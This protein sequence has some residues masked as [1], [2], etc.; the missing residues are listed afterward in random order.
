MARSSIL[1]ARDSYVAA[2]G[3]V[4][5]LHVS[6]HGGSL[7]LQ[8]LRVYSKKAPGA[9]LCFL[10]IES[11]GLQES[12][13]GLAHWGCV[14]FTINEPGKPK[15]E[16]AI[17]LVEQCLLVL[18]RCWGDGGGG[19]SRPM[20][21]SARN[22]YGRFLDNTGVAMHIIE[23][24]QKLTLDEDPDDEDGSLKTIDALWDLAPRDNNAELGEVPD[25][26]DLIK[27]E[28]DDS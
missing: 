16:A 20:N 19:S 7:D 6:V 25:A 5:G 26:H 14:V 15:A 24:D 13:Q 8:E 3:T 22:D 17:S 23:W 21:M 9:V 18:S 10:N 27:L 1:Q 11:Q 12:L 28:G 4:Q 2:L